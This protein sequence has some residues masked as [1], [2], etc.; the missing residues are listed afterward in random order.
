MKPEDD[1]NQLTFLRQAGQAK[2][3]GYADFFSWVT[4]RDLEEWGVVT[5]LWEVMDRNGE[6]FFH[7]LQMRPRP[8][9]PPD[10]EAVDSDGKRIA[11]EITELVDGRAIQA[12]KAGATFAWAQWPR[13][14][15]LK[16]LSKRIADKGKRYPVLKEGPYE[17]GYVVLIHTDEPML[18][19]ET[20][21]K[22]LEGHTFSR[23]QGV[24]RA[25]LLLSY[26]P[27]SASYPYMDLS[28][29]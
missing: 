11:I 14:K 8:T 23:P 27:R 12:H 25:I 4:D 15:F 28:L 24:T 21:R 3:R 16:S 29:S 10:A 2:A 5:T 20:V 18:Q 19:I 17:G 7:K 26:D 9:D 13:D 22:H 1:E 6:A